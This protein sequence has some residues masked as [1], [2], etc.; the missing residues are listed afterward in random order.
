M[1]IKKFKQV[2]PLIYPNI[3]TVLLRDGM[4]E[5]NNN[6]NMSNNKIINVKNATTNSDAVNLQQLNEANSVLATTVSNS[7]VK[8]DGTTLLTGNLSLNGH[9]LI[10]MSSPV[11]KNDG[12]NKLYLDQKIGESHIISHENRKN[13]FEYITDKSGEF[14]A[15]Y[16]INSVNLIK[17]FDDMPHNIRKKAFSFTFLQKSNQNSQYKGKFDINL[18][19]LITN[20]FSN[21]CTLALD[22]YF[23]NI[24]FEV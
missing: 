6:L 15:D 9:K 8:K 20:N 18:F 22:F 24:T 14:T 11:N 12:V 17:N 19:K 21:N 1:L 10:N 2:L 23:M 7:Y 3:N 5:M 16:G 4:Q 13:V